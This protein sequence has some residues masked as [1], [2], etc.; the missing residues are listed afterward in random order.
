MRFA[1]NMVG[2]AAV[3]FMG[4]GAPE[5]TSTQREVERGRVQARFEQWTQRINNRELDSLGTMYRDSPNM[6]VAWSD[7]FRT[8]G[9]ADHIERTQNFFDGIQFLNLV[10][11]NPVH[12]VLTARVATTAFRYSIDMVLNDTS[13]DPYSGQA[14]LV[15]VKDPETDTWMIHNQIFSRNQ[16]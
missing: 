8:S 6:I 12:Q 4:C 5:L 3:A 11:Q 1:R 14:H 7:G 13:R 2:V 10:P 16:R 9:L 15:W